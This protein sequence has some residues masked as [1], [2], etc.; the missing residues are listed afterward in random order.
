MKNFMA[1]ITGSFT[2]EVLIFS[3]AFGTLLPVLA[4]FKLAI[5]VLG[6]LW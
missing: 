2:L 1:L 4:A 3:I 5:Y 6:G